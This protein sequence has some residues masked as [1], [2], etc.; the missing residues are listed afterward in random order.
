MGALWH[1]QGM[2]PSEQV[3]SW[4]R[5]PVDIGAHPGTPIN[6]TA[7]RVDPSARASSLPANRWDQLAMADVGLLVWV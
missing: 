1:T 2:F 3:P 4:R 5:V 7:V 6:V